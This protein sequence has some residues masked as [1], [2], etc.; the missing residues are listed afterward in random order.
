[1]GPWRK[2]QQEV[3]R[4]DEE[5]HYD[6]ASWRHYDVEKDYDAS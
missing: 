1:M 6:V 2:K 4:G 3:Q 5:K